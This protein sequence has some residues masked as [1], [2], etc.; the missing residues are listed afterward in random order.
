MAAA[1]PPA[2]AIVVTDKAFIRP[3]EASDAPAAAAAANHKDVSYFM[4]ARFP[5]PYT[6][7]HAKFWIDLCSK[8]QPTVNFGIFMLDG[9]FVG[10]I[11]LVPGSD[12]QYRTYELGYWIGRDYWGKGIMTSA[13]RGFTRWAFEAFPDILRIE[14]NVSQGNDASM[15]I[16]QRTGFQAEGVKRKAIFKFGKALDKHEFGLLREDFEGV[17]P[18]DSSRS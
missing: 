8:E 18:D 10:G 4:T 13:V 14:A 9:T 12:I 7:D 17:Q 16:L 2:N 15:K 6:L 5:S 11:G 3:Y 1:A